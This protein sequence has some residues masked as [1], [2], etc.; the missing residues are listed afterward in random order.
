MDFSRMSLSNLKREKTNKVFE[1]QEL[2]ERSQSNFTNEDQKQW[3]NLKLDIEEIESNI[4][5]AEVREQ[6][7]KNSQ[8]V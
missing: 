5:K 6:V 7:Q 8:F 1:L 2:H 4:R 3:D